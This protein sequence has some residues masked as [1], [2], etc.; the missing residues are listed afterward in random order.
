MTVSDKYVVVLANN[1]GQLYLIDKDS[2]E[3]INH[4]NIKVQYHYVIKLNKY[5]LVL[6]H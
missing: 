3:L 1:L 5:Y 6:T 2:L 4:I